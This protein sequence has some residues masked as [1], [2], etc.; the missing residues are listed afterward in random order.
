M[1]ILQKTLNF[2]NKSQ[3][4]FVNE[5]P[6]TNTFNWLG[7]IGT[8]SGVSVNWRN[9]LQ[10]NAVYTCVRTIVADIARIPLRIEKKIDGGWKIDHDNP[11]NEVLKYPNDRQVIYEIIEHI[12]FSVLTSGDSYVVVI[13]DKNGNPVKLI[14]IHPFAC[15]VIEDSKDGELYY[16]V[17]ER[18]LIKYKTSIATETGDT[19]TIYHQDMIRTRNLSFDNGLNGVS[20]I[21]IAQEAF[22]LAVA[23]Q[24]AAARAMKNG[25]HVNGYWSS[26]GAAGG[27][28]QAVQSKDDLTR[29]MAGVTNAGQS[30]IVNGYEYIPI[31]ANLENLQLIEARQQITLEICQMFRLPSYKLGLTDSEKAAN[32]SEQE[33]SYINNTLVQYTRPLEQHMDRVLLNDNQKKDFRFRFDF[34]KLAEPDEQIRSKFYQ[35]AITMGFMSPNEVREREDLAPI[36]DGDYYLHPLNTG[37]IGDGQNA[38]DITT[39]EKN[40]DKNT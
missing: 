26:T 28:E 39:G 17:T 15:S 31:S 12:I 24:E 9:A 14:P 7:N 8:A 21:Q 34:S 36:P 23:T 33:Q 27:R 2:K 20:L 16:K 1:N 4:P 29:A 5:P 6:M 37:V 3:I 22:G 10:H 11:L 30:A 13:R 19:R 18:M 38:H 35:T 25:A 32:I 40:E